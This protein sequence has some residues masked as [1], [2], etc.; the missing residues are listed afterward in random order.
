MLISDESKDLLKGTVDI[1]VHTS[2]DVFDRK[3]DDMEAVE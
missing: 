3:L 2:P 1:H